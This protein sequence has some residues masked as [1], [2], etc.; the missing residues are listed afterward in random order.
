MVQHTSHKAGSLAGSQ[1]A[2]QP[3]DSVPASQKDSSI[4][5]AAGCPASVDELV[6][7]LPCL[8]PA[9]RDASTLMRLRLYG[10]GTTT[11]ATLYS[12]ELPKKL[13]FQGTRHTHV[14]TP[15]YSMPYLHE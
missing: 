8:R 2:H 7:S 4:F 3:M 5:T 6:S 14:H 15:T 10:Y 13:G 9:D 12:V 11:Y 1:G